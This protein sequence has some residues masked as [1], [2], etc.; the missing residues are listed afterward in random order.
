MTFITLLFAFLVASFAGGTTLT[1]KTLSNGTKLILKE[2]KGKGLVAG[3]VFVKGGVYG[4]K[5]RGLT[6]LLFTLL[7]KGT[8]SYPDASAVSYPFEKFG[9]SVYSSSGEDF[10]EV[11]FATKV[12]GLEEGLKVIKEVLT[13][14]LLKEEDIEREKKNQIMAIRSKRERGMSLAYEELRKLTYAGTPY[15]TS[16]LGTEEDVKSI[17]RE[18]LLKRLEELVR[19]GNLV[20][21]LVGDFKAEEV[22]PLLEET[23]SSIPEGSLEIKPF[24]K[25]IEKDALKKELRP[26][27]SAPSTPLPRERKT[28]LPLRFTT[29]F[30]APA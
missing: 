5:K 30:S 26:P 2:T 20:V 19:G 3:V 6:A 1:E 23:F 18:D 24:D 27:S 16:P 7:L 11:G 13:K 29:A 21:V 17:T 15:E 14:P 4:E 12:E 8:E 28:T 10:S 25:K 9:G 22:L